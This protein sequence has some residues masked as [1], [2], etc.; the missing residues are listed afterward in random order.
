MPDSQQHELLDDHTTVR[1]PELWVRNHW[2]KALHSALL[3]RLGVAATQAFWERHPQR[4]AGR[5]LSSAELARHVCEE[6]ASSPL[7]WTMRV[8]SDLE[9]F[10]LEHGSDF[11]AFA[12]AVRQFANQGTF[13]H[14]RHLL[15]WLG[16]I[17]VPMFRFGNP[18]RLLLH[19]ARLVSGAMSP[20]VVFELP[21]WRAPEAVPIELRKRTGSIWVTYPGLAEREIEPWDFALQTGGEIIIAPKIFGL[22]PF[23]GLTA[24]CDARPAESVPWDA[25]CS[26]RNDRFLIDGAVHGQR[27][28]F[29][30]FLAQAGYDLPG[31]AL[32]D[33][34]VV[35]IDRDYSCARRQRVVLARGCA[36]GAPGYLC[37]LHWDVVRPTLRNFLSLAHAEIEGHDSVRAEQ[38]TELRRSY[39]EAVS[40]VLC[41]QYF[42]ADGSVQVGGKHVCR[43]TAARIL[44]ECVRIAR[45][46][47]RTEFTFR[48]LKRLPE[49]V[50]HPKNTGL[51]L[52]LAR[53]RTALDAAECGLRIEPAGRGRFRLTSDA[54]L[55]LETESSVD[56]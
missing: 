29:S 7:A 24:V 10:L 37:R 41:V 12:G 15:A 38:L 27:V 48:E 4:C 16:P 35:A 13:V 26:Y 34:M 11:S 2:V 18:Y 9:P 53:L 45:D 1:P 6:K 49:L 47:G 23:A 3:L 36:Y 31:G 56:A 19:G 55:G 39:L 22:P 44:L 54:R 46:E 8:V 32:A 30:R 17:L 28:R 42:A 25:R 33:P 5:V 52:R 14:P 20:G 50:S 51:E 40:G 43:G 21:S